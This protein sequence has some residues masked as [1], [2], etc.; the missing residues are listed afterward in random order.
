MA[1]TTTTSRWAAPRAMT[2]ATESRTAL[3]D[4][5]DSEPSLRVVLADDHPFYRSALARMLERNGFE[6]VA[7]VANGEDVICAVEDTQPDVAVV[8]LNMPGTSGLDATRHLGDLAGPVPVMVLSV[9][10]DERDVTDA[11]LAGASGYMLKDRPH[12]E[13]V[14]GIR[15]A[16]AGQAPLSPRIAALLIR[17]LRE[18]DDIDEEEI[19]RLL[20][21]YAPGL[22]ARHGRSRLP[23]H[24]FP[25]RW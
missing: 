6:V 19:R 10:A 18:T 24:R 15:A 16:A 3:D 17:R 21:G 8:D 12:A 7:E 11:I 1:R 23:T 9:S 25:R 20:A 14:A 2:R 4:P 5:V 13:I 22:A